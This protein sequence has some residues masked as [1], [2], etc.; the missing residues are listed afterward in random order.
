L[1]KLRTLK[2]LRDLSTNKNRTFLVIITIGIGVFAVGAVSR[3]WVILSNNLSQNYL[4]V[5]PSSATITTQRPFDENFVNTFRRMPEV[6]E[7]E[8][9]NDFTLRVKGADGRWYILRLITRADYNNL[10]LDK[11]ELEE[12][13]WPPPR[14]GMLLE[15]SSLNL[16]GL[17]TGDTAVVRLPNGKLDE[18]NIAGVVHDVTQTP[19]AFTYT[20]YGYITPKTLY[21]L[22]QTSDYNKLDIIVADQPFDKRHIQ[23]VVESVVDKMEANGMVVTDKEIPNPGVHQLNDII[24][25]VL[26]L[27]VILT[28]L[29]VLLGTFLVINI[30]SALLAQQVQ[31]IGVIK[32]V[33]GR[34]QSIATMYLKAMLLLGSIALVIFMPLGIWMSRSSAVFVASFIN[35]DITDYS[36]PLQIYALELTTAI[37]LP[38]VAALYPIINGARITV[39]EAIQQAGIQAVQFGTSGFEAFLNKMRGLPPIVLYAFRNIFRRKVRL[40]LATLTLSIAG[41]VFISVFSVRASL[42][43][44]IDEISTYWQE[45]VILGFYQSP[46]LDTLEHMAADVPGIS[47]LEGRLIYSG[48]RIRSDDSESTQQINLFGVNPDSIFIKPVLLDGRWLRA[49][50]D[51]SVVINIDFLE[52]E[53][54]VKVG[55]EVTFRSGSLE[56]TW[57]VVGIVT[58]QVVGGGEL[59]KAPIAYANYTSLADAVGQKGRV[60]RLLIG[61]DPAISTEAE[62]LNNLENV[63][64]EA[65]T[66][67][68]FSLL[69]S[70]VRNS[71]A[72]SFAIIINLVQL[73]SLLFAVVGG[74]GLMS[75]M[76]LNVL[77]RTQEIGIIR[78]IGGVGKHIQ[79]IVIIESLVVGL[80]SWL[81]GSLL[82]YPVSKW[83][84]TELGITMLNVPLTHIFPLQGLIIWLVFILVLAV[85]ASI[86]P[87]RNAAQL[88]IRE[89][90]TYE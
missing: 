11:I 45:D 77:E 10:T 36:I 51:K 88:I 58:S 2:I 29:A 53:P 14:Q 79:Q 41:A 32:A 42:L 86:I 55:D 73:M 30:I 37:L 78:V 62:T 81:I 75:M 3:A 90:L 24:Q 4:A 66:R 21:Q 22:T 13:N 15:R 54:D 23:D 57:Q 27:L 9:R 19:T 28:I 67:V 68:V 20:I 43:V 64:Q 38:C 65:N 74:L 80:L 40:A 26:Q 87:A 1:L 16:L 35:F 18:I 70:E 84:C 63:L 89:T 69:N 34:S 25:S 59:L 60:N 12:G 50:D 31:Q 56:T 72:S 85:L 5:S 7:A 83:M 17:S 44:T 47:V 76:S 71:L 48:F 61:T 52:L 39:R 49:D 8:G 82:A 33:G 6:G 46:R